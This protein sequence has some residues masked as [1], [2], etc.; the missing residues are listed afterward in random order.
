MTQTNAA[1]KNFGK[2]QT[3][4]DFI[5][6]MSEVKEA[7]FRAI[8]ETEKRYADELF[9]TIIESIKEIRS[10]MHNS[11]FVLPLKQGGAG[12]SLHMNFN[13]VLSELI[14][15]KTGIN[16]HPIE[17]AACYHSTNDTVST[18]FIIII[19]RKLSAMEKKVIAMQVALVKAES[20]WGN[21]LITGRTEL[22]AALP[23]TLSQLASSYSGM[24][25]RDRWRI[26]KLK[27]RIRTI[28][29]GGTAIGTGFFA[30]I[31]YINAAE[32]HIRNITGLPLCRSQNLTDAIAHHDSLAE[33]VSGIKIIASNLIKISNDFFYYS[34]STVGEMTLPADQ[35]GSTIMPAK[36]NPVQLEFVKGLCIGVLYESDKISRYVSEGNLQLNAFLP[37]M[38]DGFLN[39]TE[40]IALSLSIFANKII[41]QI[42][43]N[44]KRI[45]K[46]LIDSHA[47][48][49][50]LRS[51]VDYMLL[52]ETAEEAALITFKSYNEYLEFIS[53]KTD[54]TIEK[55]KE[56]FDS[57]NATTFTK[58]RK[59]IIL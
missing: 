32:T 15:Q 51:S 20:D 39:L 3:P 43:W 42:K 8:Q 59:E 5:E 28:S 47:L 33:V 21:T 18:A 7:I 13:E 23:M 16:F 50:T 26:S 30:P 9:D 38:I 36:I 24:L 49:N 4:F 14:M 37:F 19:Y 29:L 10:G 57:G 40:D 31:A 53:N 22:Q 6:A 17:E 52:K 2:S 56:I 41:P 27:E 44:N 48:L 12:T 11:R 25:E 35:Y 55:L 1:I 34:S 45:Q 46:N 54:I 58:S